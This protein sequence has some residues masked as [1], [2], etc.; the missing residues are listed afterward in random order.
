MKTKELPPLDAFRR[1]PIDDS[2]EYL[3]CS[4]VHLYKKVKAGELRIIKDGRRSYIPGADLIA[5]STAGA[6]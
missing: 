6:A 4:R 5:A 2:A 3:G 1:Y